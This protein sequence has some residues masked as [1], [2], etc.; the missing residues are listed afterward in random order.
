M[1]VFCIAVTI[2]TAAAIRYPSLFQPSCTSPPSVQEQPCAPSDRTCGDALA[3]VIEVGSGSRP[4]ST[5]RPA[6]NSV[7]PTGTFFN[8]S[9]MNNN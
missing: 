9:K 4:T 7:A 3:S 5:P 8:P 1:V 2:L 6:G